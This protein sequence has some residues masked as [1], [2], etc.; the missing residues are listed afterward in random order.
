[1]KILS[2]DRDHAVHDVLDDEGE[3]G[4]TLSRGALV[5]PR[6]RIDPYG[7]NP[8]QG[9]A[10]LVIQRPDPLLNETPSKSMRIRLPDSNTRQYL[11]MVDAGGTNINFDSSGCYTLPLWPSNGATFY[12]ASSYSRKYND[13]LPV[14]FDIELELLISNQVVCSDNVLIDR[15]PIDFAPGVLPGGEGVFTMF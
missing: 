6:I 8:V 2:T 15:G 1:L 12:A 13:G 5:S 11:W 4:W 9:L 14:R 10:K 7:T 3:D